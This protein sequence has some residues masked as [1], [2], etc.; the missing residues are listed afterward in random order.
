[1]FTA[2]V[3]VIL[4]LYTRTV[5]FFL[6]L[7]RVVAR[8]WLLMKIESMSSFSSPP[9]LVTGL[10]VAVTPLWVSKLFV[11]QECFCLWR[12]LVVGVRC[13]VPG[14]PLTDYTTLPMY[15]NVARP[16]MKFF[17]K[18]CLPSDSSFLFRSTSESSGCAWLRRIT[19]FP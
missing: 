17:H 4:S 11:T 3:L 12:L 10:C 15:R 18:T 9:S 2:V 19:L 6:V 5:S 8:A 7:Q 1:M 14:W 13:F 16:F